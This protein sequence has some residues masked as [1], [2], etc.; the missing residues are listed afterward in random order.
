[1]RKQS[2]PGPS[3]VGVGTRLAHPTPPPLHAWL[4]ITISCS[5]S[6]P[7]TGELTGGDVKCVSGGCKQFTLH[8]TDGPVDCQFWETDRVLPTLAVG[9]THRVVGQWDN[10][11]GVVKCFSVR[12]VGVGECGGVAR[13]VEAS[14]KAMRSFVGKIHENN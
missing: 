11:M 2:I 4:I 5:P 3:S 9:Q 14:D 8:T 6:P 10:K 13:F 12:G 7:H 1:M